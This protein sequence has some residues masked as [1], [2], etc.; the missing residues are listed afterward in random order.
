MKT[1]VA[2]FIQRWKTRAFVRRTYQRAAPIYWA[3][4]QKE[5]PDFQLSREGY[6]ALA[7]EAIMA[8]QVL[9]ETVQELAGM[10]PEAET[11]QPGIAD[12]Q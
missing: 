6:Q 8:A 1:Y 3:F 5:N 2:S 4:M 11:P 10:Q 7:L 9:D 12:G